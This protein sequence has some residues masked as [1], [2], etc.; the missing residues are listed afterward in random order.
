MKRLT[1]DQREVIENKIMSITY[2]IS[3]LRKKED[4]LRKRL[5]EANGM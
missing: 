5:E 4:K 2:K 1:Q 3:L